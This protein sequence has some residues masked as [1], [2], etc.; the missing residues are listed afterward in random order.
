MAMAELLREQVGGGDNHARPPAL[1]PL[2]YPRARKPAVAACLAPLH[3]RP[4]HT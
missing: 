1:E 3:R 4:S 2:A